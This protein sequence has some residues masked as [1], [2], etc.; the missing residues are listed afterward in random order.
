LKI[1]VV[2]S[3]IFSYFHR[4]LHCV[5]LKWTQS[6]SF[7][8]S[9]EK[10]INQQLTTKQH[11]RNQ[12]KFNKWTMGLAAV[13][14]VSLATAARADEKVSQLNTALSNTTL[15]GY[16]DV[17]AQ[18]VNANGTP[19]GL[20]YSTAAAKGDNFSLNV[21]DIALD[22]PLDATP[23]S[24]GYH[25]ELWMGAA[26]PP[27]P[28]TTGSIIRQAYL[29]L[30]TTFG[31]QEID[32]KIGVWD[33]IIGYEGLTSANNPNYTHSYGFFVEPTTHTGILGSYKVND[34]ISIQAGVAD[35]SF[36][37]GGYSAAINGAAAAPAGGAL[38]YPTLMAAVAFTAPDSFG[39]MKG[40]TLTVGGINTAAPGGAGGVSGGFGDSVYAGVTIPTPISALKFGGAFD[41]AEAGSSAGGGKVWVA[42]LYATY[43]A[44]D[45]LSF[46]GRGE[47]ADF[48][49]QGP[50]AH[51]EELTATVQYALWANVLS[52]VEV[53]WDHDENGNAFAANTV[54]AGPERNAILLAAQLIYTF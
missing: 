17:A 4:Q 33:T 7:R 31:S 40:A 28:L 53:R 35:D 1:F 6:A 48:S 32:W 23:F 41:Y 20:P 18:Y 15:S 45:K 50:S 14:V 37:A 11:R 27:P 34:D 13:G 22:K 46:N 49:G 29:A 25:V 16:V 24:A 51:F 38:H 5:V 8:N 9:A 19:G 3:R 52:R 2:K 42:G 43:Q 39:P 47:L 54:S 12:M 30:G 36:A 44:T 21:V 10:S 26:T